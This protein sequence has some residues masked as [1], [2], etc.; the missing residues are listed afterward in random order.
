M[1]SEAA[2]FRVYWRSLPDEIDHVRTFDNRRKAFVHAHKKGSRFK[3]PSIVERYVFEE[4]REEQVARLTG[5]K[6]YV[7]GHSTDAA[8]VV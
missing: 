1:G 7:A 2:I 6:F 3:T 5:T 4:G 8:G